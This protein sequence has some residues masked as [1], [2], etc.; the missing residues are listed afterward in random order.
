MPT[1]SAPCHTPP[2]LGGWVE[3]AF[4]T[5]GNVEVH[6]PTAIIRSGR[7]TLRMTI[8]QPAGARFSV[9]LLED[10]CRAN[11]REGILKRLTMILPTAS[12]TIAQVRMEVE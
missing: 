10:A 4:V 9:E 5:W 11:Q 7:H 6:G 3:E 8:E 1:N 12:Q 2:P